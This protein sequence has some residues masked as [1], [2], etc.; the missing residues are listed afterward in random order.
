LQ[1]MKRLEALPALERM[2]A[3]DSVSTNREVALKAI[4]AIRGTA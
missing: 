4:E 3:T 1:L 2:S